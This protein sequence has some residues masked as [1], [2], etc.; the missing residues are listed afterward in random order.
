M[1]RG[2]GDVYKRQI[3]ESEK[4]DGYKIIDKLLKEPKKEQNK[5]SEKD[6]VR[7][8][9]DVRNN[10]IRLIKCNSD[11]KAFITLTFAKEQDYKESK[12]H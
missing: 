2:L 6:R 3:N 9:T 5:Q 7:N 10:I 12:K 4:S 1:S 8:L 11:M